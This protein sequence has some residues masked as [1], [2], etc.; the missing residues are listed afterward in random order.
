MVTKD[1][2]NRCGSEIPDTEGESIVDNKDSENRRLT[3]EH[4]DRPGYSM[5]DRESD[6]IDLCNPCY[7]NF[8]EFM[9][10]N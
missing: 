3:A 1:F 9:E 8:K 6:D 4:E 2:C 7:I 10:N 5:Y